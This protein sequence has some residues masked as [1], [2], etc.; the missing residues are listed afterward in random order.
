MLSDP[1]WYPLTVGLNQWNAQATGSGAQP[2]YNLV[3]TGSLLTIIPIVVAFLFLQRFWQ[4]GLAGRV[5][6]GLTHRMARH[7][8][9]PPRAWRPDTAAPPQPQITKKWK[10]T[11]EQ[12]SPARAQR[13]RHRRH[14]R[15]PP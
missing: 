1:K 9:S 5:R 13:P 8:G 10:A 7:A 14:R 6:Q 2:I 15:D 4:S 11:H 12:A 3:V